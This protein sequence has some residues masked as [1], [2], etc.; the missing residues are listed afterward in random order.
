MVTHLDCAKTILS[1]RLSAED[2][3]MPIDGFAISS[4]YARVSYGI[5][6][7]NATLI[8][9]IIRIAK[10]YALPR[11]KRGQRKTHVRARSRAVA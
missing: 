9:R 7:A 4:K 8:Q 3:R 2:T 6:Y 1:V 5:H 11:S 10:L